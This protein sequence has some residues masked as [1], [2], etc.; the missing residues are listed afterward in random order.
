MTQYKHPILRQSLSTNMVSEPDLSA[1]LTLGFVAPLLATALAATTFFCAALSGRT[2]ITARALCRPRSCLTPR[3][4]SRSHEDM[5]QPR[6]CP[7]PGGASRSRRD[8]WCPWSCPEPGGGSRSH[9]DTWRPQSCPALGG[10]CWS[11]GDTW[12][13]WSCPELGGGYHS[14]APSSAPFYGWSGRGGVCHALREF[15]SDDHTGQVW[16]QGGA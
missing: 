9:G 7:K 8:T 11:P 16:H 15:T 2:T 13:P 5:W 1:A 14:T 4:G 6:S 10:V 3:G 12:R